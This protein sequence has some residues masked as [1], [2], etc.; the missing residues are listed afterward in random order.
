MR[1]AV[2]GPSP[3]AS[4]LATHNVMV[5]NRGHNTGLELKL[6]RA[7]RAAGIR[8]FRVNYLVGGTR[9]DLAFPSSKVAVLVNGCFWHRCSICKLPLPKSHRSFWTRKFRL[10]RLRDARVRS[11][12]RE[13]GWRL[14]EIWEHQARDDLGG[15]VRLVRLETGH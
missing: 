5:S 8:G 9:V 2:L 3:P 11:S 14:V 1:R 12:I 4:N 6:R 10:T 13:S 7:L 15:C